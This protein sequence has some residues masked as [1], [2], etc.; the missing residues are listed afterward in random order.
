MLSI[1]YPFILFA[2]KRLNYLPYE[3]VKM[4]MEIILDR[5]PIDIYETCGLF[6]ICYNNKVYFCAF[7][8]GKFCIEEFKFPNVKRIALHLI[9]DHY[10]Y[11]IL[12]HDG[13]LFKMD[14]TDKEKLF[15]RY[16]IESVTRVEF[17]GPIIDFGCTKDCLYAI[18][19]KNI[20]FLL[21]DRFYEIKLLIK[22]LF[23]ESIQCGKLHCMLLT[24][25][26]S[27]YVYGGNL[28][29]QKGLGDNDQHDWD[30]LSKVDIP[31]AIFINTRDDRLCAMT[32]KGVFVWGSNKCKMLGFES[33]GNNV[34]T[35]TLLEGIKMIKYCKS[36]TLFMTHNGNI[37]MIKKCPTIKCQNN[38]LSNIFDVD[39][40]REIDIP[41]IK[42]IVCNERSC[43]TV[44]HDHKILE[45]IYLCDDHKYQTIWT[46]KD[47][48]DLTIIL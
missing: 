29:G 3:L 7:F 11:F 33:N 40:L 14:Y 45:Y 8:G 31:P 42:N 47:T 36:T 4:I 10:Q 9:F 34:C 25:D 35:P 27:V 39:K 41:N 19:N 24:R 17:P 21:N 22:D 48:P 16:T 26:G 28:C 20:F 23:F 6:T 43:V 2:L 46:D 13:N 38:K 37:H 18:T 30:K 5:S 1:N 32:T 15:E 44:T 12:T